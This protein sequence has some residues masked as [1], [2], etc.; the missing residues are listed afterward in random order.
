[1][2]NGKRVSGL[3]D[4]KIKKGIL[5]TPLN[6]GL[7][8]KLKLSSW[9]KERMP[10][11]LWLGLILLQYGRKRGLELAGNILFEISKEIETLSYPRISKIFSLS[12]GDQETIYEIICKYVDRDI[13]A[14]LTLLYPSKHYPVFNEYFFVSHLLVEDRI[15]II[16]EAIRVF[17]PHQ[18]DEATDLRFLAISLM[19]MSGKVLLMEGL[20]PV[21]KSLKE[22]PYTDHED[23]KMRMYRPTVR[24]MEGG[25]NFDEND[26]SFSSDFWRDFGMITPCNPMKIEF[27]EN[28]TDFKEFLA[29]CRKVLEYVFFSNKEKALTEDKIDVIVGSINY[30][31][32]ILSEINDNSLGN[33]ILGRHGLRTIIEIYIM[34]KYLLKREDEQS[35]IWEEYKLY[36]ISKYK[37]VLLKARESNSIIDETSHFSLPVVEAIV[38]EIRWEEFIDV[39]FN[40]FDKQGIRDKSKVVGEKELYDLFYD[41]ETS[42]THGMWGAVRE[43]SM[44]HCN[45]A[46]HQFHAIPDIYNDQNLSDVKSDSNKIMILLYELLA[47]QYEIPAWFIDKYLFQK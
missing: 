37:L 3:S 21:I 2:S 32:K 9:A 27:P 23:E 43:S 5:V 17:S 16:S 7:G 31:L 13:L 6:E 33:S 39:D 12:D 46:D 38:N 44:L 41:Y 29:D 30:A 28:T 26:T 11:Y 10:E 1:M 14:P 36:G 24:S 45:S 42:F 19:I 40:Y 47:D 4:H 25:M 18:S 22:Y 8:D 35:K 34:L 20:D 15:N